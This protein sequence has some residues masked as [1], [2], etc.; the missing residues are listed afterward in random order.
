MR[1]LVTGFAIAGLVTVLACSSQSDTFATNDADAS[2]DL[3][4]A[5]SSNDN[6]TNRAE[7]PITVPSSF[8]FTPTGWVDPACIREIAHGDMVL[9][10]GRA[11]HTDG[12]TAS[13]LPTCSPLRFDTRGKRLS[14][15]AV[16]A[17][18]SSTTLVEQL[19]SNEG[20]MAYMRGQNVPP[21]SMLVA[22]WVVPPAPPR[23]QS[24]QIYLFPGLENVAAEAAN[25]DNILQPVLGWNQGEGG[26]LGWSIA[27]WNCC[28]TGVTHSQFVSVSPG[29]TVYATLS[30]FNC[31]ANGV[32]AT[33]RNSM[34]T[35]RAEAVFLD[36]SI[37]YAMDLLVPGALEVSNVTR[38]NELPPSAGITFTNERILTVGGNSMTFTPQIYSGPGPHC[39]Y[40]ASISSAPSTSAEVDATTTLSW[41]PNGATCSPGD[42][43]LCCLER[44]ATCR[45]WGTE[46]CQANG[47]YG[48]CLGSQ[49]GS[50][51]YCQ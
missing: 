18:S 37:P 23:N 7:R 40:G 3:T 33:W 6:S 49:T 28:S 15:V 2:Y 14:P 44:T 30:G 24:Q 11:V 32:C 9:Q 38:C 1:K 35:S 5:T 43:A 27:L 16:T 41:N 10:G 19:P 42:T 47:E 20:Y 36:V 34:T 25:T 39:G 22:T 48:T 17:G 4:L 21:V 29:D 13:E 51:S 46:F 26:P 45:C 12:S 50:G 8:I 31:N